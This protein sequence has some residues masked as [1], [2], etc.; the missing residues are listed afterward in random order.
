MPRSLLTIKRIIERDKLNPKKC[1]VNF[2]S[3]KLKELDDDISELIQGV[4]EK[5]KSKSYA[6]AWRNLEDSVFEEFTTKLI[7]NHRKN[8]KRI[9]E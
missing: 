2:S 3:D 8:R 6:G 4:N 9:D 5:N 1:V 7:D